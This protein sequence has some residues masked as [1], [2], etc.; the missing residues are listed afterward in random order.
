VTAAAL[1]LHGAVTPVGVSFPAGL[2]LLFFFSLLPVCL[3]QFPSRYSPFFCVSQFRSSL[4]LPSR[5]LSLSFPPLSFSKQKYF[6][7][8]LSFLSLSSPFMSCTPSVFIGR[9]REGHPALPSHGR[10]W[11]QHGG[12]Y[13]TA[14]PA[15]AGYGPFGVRAWWCQ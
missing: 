1:L 13:Y 15:S 14:A 10:A 6:Q 4:S 8:S 7:L 12:G 11:W 2:S 3:S 9:G 5:F